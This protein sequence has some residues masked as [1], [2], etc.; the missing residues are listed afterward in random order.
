[1]KIIER[2]ASNGVDTYEEIEISIGPGDARV[3]LWLRSC[4]NGTIDEKGITI[5]RN[6]WRHLLAMLGGGK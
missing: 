6:T 5:E 1:M 3:T 2:V 4:V